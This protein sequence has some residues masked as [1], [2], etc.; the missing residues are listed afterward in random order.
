M[1]KND[2]KEALNQIIKEA[3]I[4][5]IADELINDSSLNSIKDD[6]QYVH[7]LIMKLLKDMAKT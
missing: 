6:D 1:N 4:S 3:Q 5:S 7:E 2:R